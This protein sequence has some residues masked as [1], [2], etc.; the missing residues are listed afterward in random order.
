MSLQRISEFAENQEGIEL[1]I[2]YTDRSLI[3]LTSGSFH[4]GRLGERRHSE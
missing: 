2:T 1:F 4:L 3:R